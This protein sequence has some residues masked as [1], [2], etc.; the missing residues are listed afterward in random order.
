MF[1]S[2]FKG[3]LTKDAVS[4]DHAVFLYNLRKRN[5]TIRFFQLFILV[6]FFLSWEVLARTEVINSFLMS[7]PSKMW[8]LFLQMFMDGRLYQHIKI[9][10]IEDI[11]GFTSGTLLGTLIAISLWWSD[12]LFDLLEPYIIIINSI[13]KVALG[14][15]IIVWLGNGPTAIIVMALLVSIVVTI[16]MLTNGFREVENNKIKL[17]H[18]LGANKIQ[19]LLK[20]ILPSSI[21]TIFS[22]IK[23]S[24]GLSLVGTIVGEFLVSKAGLGYLIV[25]GGQ[26]FNLHMV[27]TS[28]VILSIIAGLMYYL[29]VLMENIII[30][31]K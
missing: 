21:P 24:V 7:Q 12:Y 27:M 9:T 30:K 19:V 3:I 18:T 29:V 16:L 15:V 26:V 20:V 13:P 1:K 2:F 8:N 31:W 4:E 17:L 5:I 10:L 28:I 14:P 25:Y 22:A 6:G 11:I 23:V